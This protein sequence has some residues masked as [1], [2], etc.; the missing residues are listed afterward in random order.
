MYFEITFE[1][2]YKENNQYETFKTMKVDTEQEM[3]QHIRDNVKYIKQFECI[4]EQI[5]TCRYTIYKVSPYPFMK[6]FIQTMFYSTDKDC[7]H[8]LIFLT[9]EPI[10]PGKD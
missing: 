4:C 2:Q 3:L 5:S 7:E 8:P 6:T 9:K 1:Y 10:T